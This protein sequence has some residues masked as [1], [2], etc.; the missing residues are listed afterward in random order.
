MKD[1]PVFL[2][3][4]CD[5]F[6][7]DMMKKVDSFYELK[8]VTPPGPIK[9]FFSQ[10]Y[11]PMRSK[12]YENA[13]LE[14]PL[15]INVKYSDNNDVPMI[16]YIVNTVNASGTPCNYNLPLST[17]PRKPKSDYKP[18]VVKRKK[19]EW[20]IENSIFKDYRFLDDSLVVQCLDF[21]WKQSK[22]DMMIKSS[23]EKEALKSLLEKHYRSIIET[24]KYYSGQGGNEYFSIGTN[25]FTDFLNKGNFIDST[26]EA[27]DLGVN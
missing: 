19:V 10:D 15:E 4:E 13:E 5:M 14:S 1:S 27:S 8:R 23:E 9:F 18:P 20:N 17:G 12:D 21:D 26:Y 11:L 2:H 3:L 24:F 25:I 7:P 6:Q 16:M 22:L